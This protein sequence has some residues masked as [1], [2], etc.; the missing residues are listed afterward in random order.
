M[1]KIAEKLITTQNKYTPNRQLLVPL[2]T[3]TI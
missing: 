1:P 2:K 3:I